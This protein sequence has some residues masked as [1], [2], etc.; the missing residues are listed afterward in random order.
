VLLKRLK[1]DLALAEPVKLGGG[2]KP[3]GGEKL[4]GPKPAR[5]KS[6]PPQGNVNQRAQGGKPPSQSKG[7]RR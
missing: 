4:A 1:H 2:D 3:A 7:G 6:D 5:P